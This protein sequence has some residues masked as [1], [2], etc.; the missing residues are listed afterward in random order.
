MSNI[1]IDAYTAG[2]ANLLLG[3]SVRTNNR[4][5]MLSDVAEMFAPRAETMTLRSK[6]EPWS[7][8]D[9]YSFVNESESPTGE[10]TDTT[11]ML[12]I[13]IPVRKLWIM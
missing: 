2:V 11:C 9:E 7:H 10:N 3:A 12:L 5:K 1:E 6:I 8:H 13:F 4:T